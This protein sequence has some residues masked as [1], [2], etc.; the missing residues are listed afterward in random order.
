MSSI[1]IQSVEMPKS[2]D[3]CKLR[4]R[5]IDALIPYDTCF[6]TGIII[7][8]WT[9][10]MK[11]GHPGNCPFTQLKDHGRLID[12]DS[13]WVEIHQIC[14]R[15]DAGIISDLTCINQILSAVRHAPTII[16]ADKEN[17]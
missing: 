8:P 11:D 10:G 3:R 4:N 5:H 17:T 16:Q 9:F 13:L 6:W 14:D 15:R 2:C 12:V 1:L 7:D